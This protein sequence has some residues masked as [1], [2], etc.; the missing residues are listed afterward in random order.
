MK[1]EPFIDTQLY[2]Q[3]MI[4]ERLCISKETFHRRIRPFVRAAA[5]KNNS[6]YFSG[7]DLNQIKYSKKL[8]TSYLQDYDP[9]INQNPL[10]KLTIQQNKAVGHL[11]FQRKAACRACFLTELTDLTKVFNQT[12]HF[13]LI[14]DDC[15]FRRINQETC[16][17]QLSVPKK[18]TTCQPYRYFKLNYLNRLIVGLNIIA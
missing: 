6:V 15:H 14:S 9:K 7:H 1:T 10:I 18:L 2:N 8:S 12:D 17:L 5:Q 4:T 3:R 16:C 13:K 11:Y